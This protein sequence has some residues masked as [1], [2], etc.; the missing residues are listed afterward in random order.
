MPDAS[1]DRPPTNEELP[2]INGRING[3]FDT[4]A[5]LEAYQREL[6]A[7]PDVEI[8]TYEDGY[9]KLPACLDRRRG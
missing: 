7:V 3:I 8:E 1:R 9:P 6:A 5:E 2:I 4:L